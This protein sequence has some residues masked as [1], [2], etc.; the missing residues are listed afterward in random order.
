M[1]QLTDQYIIERAGQLG[2]EPALL[3]AVDQKE[4]RGSGFIRSEG[5]RQGELVILFERHHFSRLTGRRYDASHPSISSSSRGGYL[6]G[7]REWDRLLSAIRLNN[8]A[9]LLSTSWGR[10]QIMGFNFKVC[11]YDRVQSMINDF[12]EGESRQFD[13]FIRFLQG[14]ENGG[15]TLF[16]LLRTKQWARFARCYNGP[17]FKENRYDTDLSRL[18]KNISK[19]LNNQQ[20][21]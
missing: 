4:S 11:G 21:G 3:L 2:I 15:V 17:R 13:A 1:R 6:G 7:H 8:V 9:A 16:D 5:P 14:T 12:Y 18:Y 19:R 10:Y 20:N